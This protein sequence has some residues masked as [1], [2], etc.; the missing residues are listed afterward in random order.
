MLTRLILIRHGETDYSL[1]KRYCGITDRDLNN[2]G[3]LQAHELYSRL[4]NHRIDNVYSS[5]SKRALNFAKIVFD[6]PPIETMTELREM[7]FGIFE[8]LTHEELM[9]RYRETYT[10]WIDNPLGVAIPK[11]EVF[12]DF[13]NR[14]ENILTKIILLN[15]DKTVAVVTHAGPIK[16]IVGS[17]LDTKDIWEVRPELASVS[18]IDFTGSKPALSLSN[19]GL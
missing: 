12:I 2:R 1:R 9:E 15:K 8:G 10:Q 4:Q 3:R 13:K 11:G 6:N 18:I 16:I 17:V 14:V 5:D 7:D 19:A